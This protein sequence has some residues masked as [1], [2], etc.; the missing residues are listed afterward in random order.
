MSKAGN[1]SLLWG[2]QQDSENESQRWAMF[3]C[4]LPQ[5]NWLPRFCPK[6]RV[7]P[8]FNRHQKEA[9]DCQICCSFL[10]KS[11]DRLCKKT[12]QSSTCT[13]LETTALGSCCTLKT[14]PCRRGYKWDLCMWVDVGLGTK[15]KTMKPWKAEWHRP[16]D[17][18]GVF[19]RESLSLIYF[20][21]F[22]S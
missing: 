8:V 9:Q 17:H 4:C 14:C 21:S 18:V 15:V 16:L 3:C 1:F 12:I 6:K 10:A 11:L 7:S 19:P 22:F 5:A 20:T 13:A 2:Y